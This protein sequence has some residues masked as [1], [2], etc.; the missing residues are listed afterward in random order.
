M[1]NGGYFCRKISWHT[2]NN[3]LGFWAMGNGGCFGKNSK[4]ILAYKK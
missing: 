4:N 1:R 3:F 2:K